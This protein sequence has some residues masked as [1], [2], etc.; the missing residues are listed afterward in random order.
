[1]QE[2]GCQIVIGATPIA[3][4][5]RGKEGKVAGAGLP[6]RHRRPTLLPLGG[7]RRGRLKKVLVTESCMYEGEQG[8]QIIILWHGSAGRVDKIVKKKIYALR[9]NV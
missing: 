4:P 2:Q 5:G 3:T 7:E 1:M 6:D 9:G 8:C